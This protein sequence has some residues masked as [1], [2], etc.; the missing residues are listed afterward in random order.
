MI[1]TIL[2]ANQRN[3]TGVDK[4]Y[5]AHCL[6]LFDTEISYQV[7][8][9]TQKTLGTIQKTEMLIKKNFIPYEQVN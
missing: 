1:I 7:D 9:D 2:C 5:A 6:L 3:K 8:G 4:K